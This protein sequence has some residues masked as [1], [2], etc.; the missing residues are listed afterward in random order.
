MSERPTY[1]ELGQ[2]VRE[3]QR[4]KG[5][6]RQT[7]ERYRRLMENLNEVLYMLDLDARVTYVS[8]NIEKISG[9]SREEII[10]RAFIDFVHPD[11]LT[12]RMESFQRVLMGEGITTEYRYLTN[13]S[14]ETAWVMTKARPIFENNEVVGIQGILVDISERKRAEEVL[15]ESEKKFRTLF[16]SSPQAIALTDIKTGRIIDVNDTFCR[17]TKYS[18]NELIGK[19]TTELGFYSQDDRNRFIHKLTKT[20]KVN[21]IEMDFKISDGS[22]L[23][24]RMFAVPIKIDGKSSVLTSFFDM[25]EQNRLEKQLLQSQKMESVGRLAGGVAHDFNNMLSVIIGNAEVAMMD[26]DPDEP[27]HKIL[28]EILNAGHRSADITRQLLAFARKQT[29]SPEVLD[30]NETVEGMLKMLRRLIGE[31]IDLAWLP[32][33]HLGLINVDPSQINQILANL[34]VNARDAI[35]G[36]G[37]I[38]VE[39]DNVRLDENYSAHHAGFV[40]GDFVMLAVSDDGCGMDKETLNNVFEPFFTTKGVNEG[41]GLGLATVYGIVKQNDGFINVYSEPEKGTTVRIYVPRHEG[42]SRQFAAHDVTKISTARGE[43][44]LIVEDEVHILELVKTILERLGYTVLEAA[45][46][47]RAVALAEDHK[48]EIHLLMTD[49]VM[50]E[51]NGRDLADQLHGLYPDLKVLFMSGYTANAIAHCGVLDE[52]MNFIPKP[53]SVKD[54][55]IKVREVLDEDKG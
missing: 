19:T 8:P 32:G 35:G 10:G 20:G 54:L 13:R 50:P 55:S 25:T 22:M 37:K 36:M 29:I 46:P 38:T 4:S 27:V 12:D 41:T 48:G 39:T 53:F 21:G 1:E 42:E 24:S 49:V 23:N 9:Y 2:Q 16:D 47:G 17:L 51:M 11:D 31:D 30:L 3:L 43:T 26:T 34:M 5:K 6:Y 14:G 7:A 44:V 52:G 28:K 15:R 18:K 33:K 40:P 45:T